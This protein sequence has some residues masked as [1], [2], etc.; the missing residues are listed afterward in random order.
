M[1][2]G[3]SMAEE[4]KYHFQVN[5]GGLLDVLANHLYTSP[6]VFLRELLQNGMD[7]ITMRKKKAAGWNDGKIMIH[8]DSGQRMIFRDN[9]SGLNEE[10]IHR[11]LAV[12]GQSSKHQVMDGQIQEDYIGRFGI[13]LLSCFMV[14]E[15]IVVYTQSMQ[16][17][18][19]YV[20]TGMADGTYTLE[21]FGTAEVGTAIILTAKK[22]MEH[23]FTNDE[24]I[25][26]VQFYGL[27]LPVPVHLNGYMERVK[28][29]PENFTSMNRGNLFSFG[30][31]LFQEEFLDAIP[32]KTAHLEGVVYVLP[33]ETS[34]SAKG[35][36]RIYLKNM[37]LT[38]QGDGLLP[39]W[40][41][42]LKCFLNTKGL[43]PTASREAFYE[44]ASLAQA[45]EELSEVISAH[46]KHLV[47]ENPERLQAI[48]NIHMRAI[49]AMAKW[50]EEMLGL[51]FDYLSFETNDG[52]M[53]GAD[54][55]KI[56]EVRYVYSMERFKQ[57]KSIFL[58]KGKILICA[59]YS[60]DQELLEY[61]RRLG[62]LAI[63]RLSEEELDTTFEEPS[64]VQSQYAEALR[65]IA[66]ECMK[67]FDCSVE[68]KCF[69]PADLPAL[70][71]LSD[72]VVF[73]RNVQ[74][75]MDRSEGSIFSD[76]LNLLLE[77]VEE[78]PVA[79]LYL[80]MNSMLIQRLCAVQDRPKII[81]A[82]QILYIQALVAGGHTLHS[83]ELQVMSEG[84]LNLLEN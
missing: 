5:L 32:V 48:I 30:E 38:E 9:G 22:G 14:S 71:T 65:Q 78:R 13:G 49:K 34:A 25:R 28:Y 63:E 23:Y 54:L 17:G 50:N 81:S 59:G 29:V 58:A 18:P 79:T 40:S 42:F 11:F 8:V 80:N 44:D 21:E 73:L 56:Q 16:G 74:S 41:F 31:W 67:A 47:Y 46:F 4:K 72:E 27:M 68:V 55:K 10:E 19:A 76:T 84:L 24:I 70:Y 82:V 1:Y 36:H 37:L 66:N 75:A 33:Y 69:L 15:S 77:D 83:N 51:F 45:K 20:W 6:D 64:E 3:D 62:L 7:A 35:Q 61:A 53:T 39:D 52:M 60:Y 2:G 43:R 26:L 12:I 57:L